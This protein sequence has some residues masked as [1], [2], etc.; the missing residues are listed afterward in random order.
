MLLAGDQRGSI[1]DTDVRADAR[2]EA[3]C[4]F[5]L[6]TRLDEIATEWICRQNQIGLFDVPSIDS[7][8]VP[9]VS[10]RRAARLLEVVLVGSIA[11]ENDRRTRESMR[12]KAEGEEEVQV[13]V[14]VALGERP[15]PLIDEPVVGPTAQHVVSVTRADETQGGGTCGDEPGECAVAS[16][17]GRNQIERSD[18]NGPGLEIPEKVVGQIGPGINVPTVTRRIEMDRRRSDVAPTSR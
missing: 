13:A 10:G 4:P 7:D 2:P 14:R 17:L 11:I 5:R 8:E 1:V 12:R 15:N 6:V 16:F 18:G 9:V 3:E